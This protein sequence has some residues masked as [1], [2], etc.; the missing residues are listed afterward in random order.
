V[1]IVD[2]AIRTRYK[3]LRGIKEAEI[4]FGR[5]ANEINILSGVLR[6]LQNIVEEL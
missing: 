3:L 6:S 2:V 1:Q 4:S 5:L